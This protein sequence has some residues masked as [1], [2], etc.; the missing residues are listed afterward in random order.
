MSSRR[1]LLPIDKLFDKL[2]DH[3]PL[4]TGTGYGLLWRPYVEREDQHTIGVAF[5]PNDLTVREKWLFLEDAS[6]FDCLYGLGSSFHLNLAQAMI[7][8]WLAL[9]RLPDVETECFDVSPSSNTR[10]VSLGFCQGE[11]IDDAVR[12][13]L[14]Y[15]VS[16]PRNI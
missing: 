13:L 9:G 16:Q 15:Q 11:T 10:I 4:L 7:S 12:M 2:S 14:E 3:P 1:P 8:E 5:K 6:R